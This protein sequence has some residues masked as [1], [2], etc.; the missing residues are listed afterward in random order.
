MVSWKI[1]N[2]M[3]SSYLV[4]AKDVVDCMGIFSKSEGLYEVLYSQECFGSKY[5]QD[6]N[7]LMN[8]DFCYDCRG[9]DHCFMSAG[10]RN[11]KYCFKNR[12]YSKHEYE[13]IVSNYSLDSWSGVEKTKKEFDEFLISQPRKN[14]NFINC[15]NCFGNN[16]TNSKNSKNAF[17]TKRAENCRYVENGDTQKDSYD[18]SVG[19]E[20]EQCYEGVTP[21][22]STRAFFTNCSW[23]NLDILYT[24][25][26]MSCQECFGCV[27]LKHAKYSIFN[28]EYEK[29][30]YFKLKDKIIEYMKKTGEWGQFFP[31]KISPFAYNESVAQVFFPLSK[32]EILKQGLRWQENIQQTKGKTTLF[33]IPDKIE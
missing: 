8:C 7:S 9:C 16:L 25:H 23:K 32:D 18:L 24:D 5:L 27:G 3:Y 12:E 1:E 30:E 19:G 13:K 28:K 17:H 15:V 31:M 14:V 20:L 11:K 29:E 21:D 22:N 10:L 6:C 33:E 2:C 26:C 4:D